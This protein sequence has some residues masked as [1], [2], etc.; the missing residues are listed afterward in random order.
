[1]GKGFVIINNQTTLPDLPRLDKSARGD[2]HAMISMFHQL[3]CLYMTR[4]GYFAARS[5]NLDDVNVPH[6]MHCWDYLRQG[7]MCS[8]DTTLEWLAPEDT[9]STGW[10]YRHTCKDFGAIYAWAEEH[11]LTDNKWIH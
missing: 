5:G 10:G 1:E 2:K 7:I 11:R 9:G 4:A 6:L 3:H 8:A